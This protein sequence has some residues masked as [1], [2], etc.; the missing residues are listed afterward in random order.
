MKYRDI[1]GFEKKQPKK[2]PKKKVEKKVAPKPTTPPITKKLKE[3]FGPLNE[4][5][6]VDTGPKRWSGNGLTEFE[7]Q[8]G[9]D[10]INE[11]P[12]YEYEKITKDIEKKKEIF[13]KEVIKFVKLLKKKGLGDEGVEVAKLY[14]KYVTKFG[15]ELK[16]LLRKLM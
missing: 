15:L 5:G 8:G 2:Q 1:L 6:E 16:D 11:G 13:G 3:Q 4:W 10:N 7:Q 12:A 9:K 14:T